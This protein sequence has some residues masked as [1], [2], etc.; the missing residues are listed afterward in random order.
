M[1]IP[2]AAL[3]SALTLAGLF[4]GFCAIVRI[5]GGDVLGGLWLI[6]LSGVFDVADGAAA[7]LVRATS[8]FGAELDS[9]ADI[10][11]FGVAPS[12]LL[13][14][15]SLKAMGPAGLLLSSLPTL[16]GCFRLARFNVQTGP[17]D[18]TGFV[19]LPIPPAAVVLCSFVVLCLDSTTGL[20]AL[21]R[22]VLPWLVV[23]VCGLM[24]SRLRYPT[25]PRPSLEGIRKEPL[26]STLMALGVVAVI[27]G[28]WRAIFPVMS[29]FAL[30]PLF[31]ALT[32]AARR[33]PAL[34]WPARA[35]GR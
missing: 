10:V 18:K 26:K 22:A 7:R 31:R 21:G 28:G 13:Y 33:L 23:L 32:Q 12:L 17:D 30:A 9:L 5:V 16:C 2:R 11:C 3:P 15:V 20:G 6:V 1:R 24:V 8:R 27:A 25:V 19:G 29:C 34:L 4:F 14:E 35:A